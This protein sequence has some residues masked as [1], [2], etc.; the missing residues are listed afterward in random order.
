MNYTDFAAMARTAGYGD[1][2][3]VT[4]LNSEMVYILPR[5]SE[6]YFWF[7]DHH[8][9]KITRSVPDLYNSWINNEIQPTDSV[10]HPAF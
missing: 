7:Q 8:L 5:Q 6:I 1:P 3:A 2:I 4:Q 9:F 10:V